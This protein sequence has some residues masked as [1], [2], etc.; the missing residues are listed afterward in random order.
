MR[1][2]LPVAMETG[3]AGYTISEITLEIFSSVGSF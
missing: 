2:S 1:D 3:V